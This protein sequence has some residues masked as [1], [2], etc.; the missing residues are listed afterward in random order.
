LMF[1]IETK[2]NIISCRSTLWPIL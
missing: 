1:W 2:G